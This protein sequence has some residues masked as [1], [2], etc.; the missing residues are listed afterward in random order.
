M[1]QPRAT[2]VIQ[3]PNISADMLSDHVVLDHADRHRRRIALT[4]DKGLAFL[5]DLER[6]AALQHGD[7]LALD[8]GRLVGVRAAP[9]QLYEVQ[10]ADAK[11]LLR[12]AWHIGN[13]HAAAE[14]AG[15][16]IYIEE[17]H[18]LGDMLR[19][20]GCRVAVVTRPFH[21]ERGAYDS[22]HSH[23][24]HSHGSHSHDH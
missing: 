1:A 4:G 17:D 7:V 10:A 18:V 23:G 20:L 21:P 9:Q 16:V 22:G 8:D 24:G 5:L 6:A 12:V 14:I 11:A 2:R 19:G 13:R 3:Q 15:D